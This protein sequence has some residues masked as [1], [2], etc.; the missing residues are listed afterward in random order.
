MWRF[1]IVIDID[2]E[3]YIATCFAG[4]RCLCGEE[5]GMQNHLDDII[6]HVNQSRSDGTDLQSDDQTV[7]YFSS[8]FDFHVSY[9]PAVRP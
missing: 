7:G 8:S 6:H 1:R 3:R 2:R 5:F 9:I 4:T